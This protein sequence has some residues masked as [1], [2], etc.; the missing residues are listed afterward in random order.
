MDTKLQLATSLDK[1]TKLTEFAD[2]VKYVD[3][4]TNLKRELEQ[5]KLK[6]DKDHNLELCGKSYNKVVLK[7]NALVGDLNLKQSKH[8]WNKENRRKNK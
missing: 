5:L 6:L 2:R 1:A 7:I 3:I 8:L 4:I